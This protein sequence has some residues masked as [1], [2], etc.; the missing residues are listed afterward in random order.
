MKYKYYMATQKD[1]KKYEVT[2]VIPPVY[3]TIARRTKR[4][5]SMVS[6]VMAGY[7]RCPVILEEAKRIEQYLQN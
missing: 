7:R 1:K 2:V 6:K 5:L 4:S 3:A